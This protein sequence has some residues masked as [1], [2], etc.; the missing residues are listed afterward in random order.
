[1]GF[2]KKRDRPSM[3]WPG[4]FL[5]SW[6]PVHSGVCSKR[7]NVL[8]FFFLFLLPLPSPSS[9]SFSFV[10]LVLPT[11]LSSTAQ[12]TSISRLRGESADPIWRLGYCLERRESRAR[13]PG[14]SHVGDSHDPDSRRVLFR[15]V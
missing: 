9:L 10:L 8:F 7:H 6:L 12:Q 14:P 15:S 3:Y 11:D 13:I 5:L 1:M 4:R 2:G